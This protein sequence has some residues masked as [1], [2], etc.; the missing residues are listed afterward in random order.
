MRVVVGIVCILTCMLGGCLFKD[1]PA[2]VVATVNGKAITLPTLEALQEADMS[3]MGIFEQFSLHKLREQYGRALGSLIIF[4]LMLQD[5]ESKGLAVTEE[6]V[7]A[8]EADIR[9]DYPDDEFEKYFEENDLNLE[10]W[11]TVLRY[12]LASKLFTEQVLR[13]KFVPSL[14]K[15]E[16]Y[17]ET[18]KE[19]FTLEDSYD[20]YV[21]NAAERKPLQGIKNVEDILAKLGELS[22]SEVSLSKSEVP[23]DWQKMVYALKDSACTSI[24]KEENQFLI[25]CLKEHSPSKVLTAGEAYIYIEDLLA[26]EEMAFMFENWLKEKMLSADIRIS[27]HLKQD[28]Q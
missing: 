3:G 27:K 2:H 22:P 18:H 13:K 8:Y 28:I 10:A 26:E 7:Q 23:Q 15:V 9:A 1:E 16:A 4:E 11:R 21:A 17:Y 6:R 20:L 19:R 25:I 24:F 14:E 5:L 12:N